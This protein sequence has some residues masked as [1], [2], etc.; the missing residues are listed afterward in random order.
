M[1]LI[2]VLIQYVAYTVRYSYTY[3]IPHIVA[4]CM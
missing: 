1:S 4:T 2:E 3:I